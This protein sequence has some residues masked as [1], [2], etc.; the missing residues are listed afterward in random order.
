MLTIDDKQADLFEGW[1]PPEFL[2]LSE[3]LAFVDR[4]LDDSRALEPFL[5]TAKSTGRPTIPIAA[6]LRLMYLKFRYQMSYEVLVKEV[7]DSYKWRRFCH[8]PLS[9]RVPDDKTLIKLTGRYGEEGVRAVFDAVVR[10]AVEAKVIR[11]RKMRLDTTVTESN[12][13]YPTDMGLLSDGVRVVTRTIQ[14]IKD[15]VRLKTGF[16]SRVRA[17]K[18]R[19]IRM[20]KFLKGRRGATAGAFRRA[21]EDVLRVAR[22]VWKN[23]A[24]VLR[25]LEQGRA[26]LKDATETGVAQ[27]VVSRLELER[28]QG[29]FKRVIEQTRRVLDGNIHIPGRLVSLFD[30]GA[31]PIQK[32]KLFPKTEFGRKVLIQEAEGGVV[33]G[34]QMHEGNPPDQG[35]L[36]EAIDRHENIFGKPPKELAA[37]RGFHR[38]GQDGG[39]HDRGIERVSIPI[40]GNKM[41]ERR[42]TERSA[43]FRRLQRWRAGGEAKISLLKRKYGLRRTA[44]RG[45]VSTAAWVGWGLIAHNLVMLCRLGMGP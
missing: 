39:L 33:T 18:R 43:W 32:G 41:P 9:G 4:T 8:L 10:R 16:R 11:G 21:K 1:I 12:I 19:M 34:W 14:K 24:R 40:K 17:M 2:T 37:D 35:M 25:E 15:V 42:R 22:K 5:K 7:S 31:R 20:V 38:P 30:E 6:Y 23:A 13:H 3:E 29:L 45:T 26:S 44:V 36:A 28:W 27:A